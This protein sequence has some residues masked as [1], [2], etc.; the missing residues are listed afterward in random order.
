MTK[1]SHLQRLS[2]IAR[3]AVQGVGFRPFVYRLATELGL[4]GWVNNTSEGVFMEV[5]GTRTELETFLRRLPLE[6]PDRAVIQG[7]ETA[8]LTPV[9]YT[10]FE[11]RPSSGGEKTAI[12][13]PDLATCPDCLAD[14]FDP[15]NRRYRYPF[16]NCTHCGP[17]YSIIE[18][19]PYDR[20][21][22]SLKRFSMCPDCQGEYENPLDRRFHAQPNACPLCGPK[23]SLLDPQGRL[24]AERE[25]ALI[26]TANAIRA[27]N[28]LALKGLGGFHL[29]VDARDDD[30]IDRLR[31]R[32][33]RPDKPFAVMYPSLALVERDCEV[34]PLQARLLQ[35][36]ECPIVL[37]KQKNAPISPA[38]APNNP[39][40]G[41]MLPYT[42]LHH[43]LMRDLGF[44]IVATSGNLADEP[45]CIE[46]K[47]AL[48]RLGGIA[49]L[50][51][52]HDR[53]I[54]RP[55]DDS[56]VRE[57]AGRPMVLRRARGYAP[58]PIEMNQNQAS[59][60]LAVGGYFKNSI[61][62]HQNNQ[63]FISQHIGDLETRV[64]HDHFQS[65]L[66]SL[67]QLYEFSPDLIACDI[68]PDYP[69]TKYAHSLNSPVISIQ[70]HYAHVLSCM[71][72][73]QLSAPILGV[74]WDGTGYGLDGTI[75]GGEFLHIT[76]KSWQR[77][78]HLRTW[79]LLGGEKAVKEP[80]RVALG[81]LDVFGDISRIEK[82]FTPREWSILQ[83]MLSRQINT[84]LTS[85]A[86][87]LFDGV[88]ALIGLHYQLS[89]EGQGAMALEFA[90]EG[91]KTAEYYPYSWAGSSPI[92]LDW[93]EMIGAIL[94]DV[95][96]E[97][98]A[99][100]ISSKFHN[101]LSEII[102]SIAQQV[103]EENIVLSGG[104]FQNCY[105][106]ERTIFRLQES[107]FKPH[108]H[109][110]VPPNDGGIS[111]GQILG[112]IRDSS[113]QDQEIS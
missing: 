61:A 22:T 31:Q 93:T 20:P 106:T 49:D 111:L 69:T 88:A 66:T 53:S 80:R 9:G 3:G 29:V 109:R 58:F 65:I 112:A 16:T 74:A 21:N 83:Q 59:A 6:K 76:P 90:L 110:L 43:L 108:W 15:G 89:F 2:L 13:L 28:I 62:I 5:E 36:S 104:C 92:I 1:N 12:V 79:K 52:V 17:R 60:I 37:L 42:P 105:L 96:K 47:E 25:P 34:S 71:A 24:I 103:G 73:N 101:T 48:E 75:W 50:F 32:K 94:V 33:H 102:V 38:V 23:I 95:E 67:K 30:G 56:I 77:V 100:I 86:G 39:Y 72:E 45:I 14:I 63:T 68:H 11:I 51:L 107:G 97:I 7:L 84:P 85:S 8:W 99:K 57:M 27:G 78:A 40:L 70:H 41:V 87:R 19:L 46:E 98:S 54:V 91:V 4:T 35:S 18:A 26:A 113:C 44:P 64:A 82:A 10:I 81:L 55:V